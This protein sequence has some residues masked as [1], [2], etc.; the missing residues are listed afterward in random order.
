MRFARSK[1]L[2]GV[3]ALYTLSVNCIKLLWL[4]RS[5]DNNLPV[6][7]AGDDYLHNHDH[8]CHGG[9]QGCWEKECQ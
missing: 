4:K 6:L 9:I 1:C 7:T 3:V 2:C 5:L 8:H